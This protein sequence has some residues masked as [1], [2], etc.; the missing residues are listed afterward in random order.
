M[1][2]KDRKKTSDDKLKQE[3]GMVLNVRL[4]PSA[5]SIFKALADEFGGN[6]K[7][8]EYMIKNHDQREL[9]L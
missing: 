2:A 6:K 1:T 9:G 3:G 8:I 5:A 4:S 7:A